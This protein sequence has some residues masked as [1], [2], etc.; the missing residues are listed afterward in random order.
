MCDQKD[1]E[2]I[3]YVDFNGQSYSTP[4]KLNLDPMC[5]S[6]TLKNLGN[7][8]CVLDDEVLQPGDFKAFGGNRGEVFTGRHNIYFTVVG[9][10]VPPVTPQPLAWFTQKFYVPTPTGAKSHLP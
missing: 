10:A 4:Q 7:T 6:F 1:K 5:N 3:L 2:L 8:L 9:M